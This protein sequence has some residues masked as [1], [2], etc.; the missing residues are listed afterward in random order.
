MA[1]LNLLGI[2]KTVVNDYRYIAYNYSE[3]EVTIND[4]INIP[5]NTFQV[6][7]NDTLATAHFNELHI[8]GGYRGEITSLGYSNDNIEGGLSI[9]SN[10]EIYTNNKVQSDDDTST[11]RIMP[12]T[13]VVE[14]VSDTYDCVS[15]TIAYTSKL[16][17]SIVI[18]SDD[19]PSENLKIN[20][21]LT[22]KSTSKPFLENLSI[23]L[24]KNNFCCEE[25]CINTFIL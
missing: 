15:D 22:S 14:N 4:A 19:Q 18:T 2:N 3:E 11:T 1:N 20:L 5:P 16:D 6:G 12:M 25:I 7:I 13:R 17:G 9:F 8:G 23:K 24:I 21:S 10:G